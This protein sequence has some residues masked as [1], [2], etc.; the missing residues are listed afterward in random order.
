MS[1]ERR[2]DPRV[3]FIALSRDIQQI[4]KSARGDP[5]DRKFPRALTASGH[6][7]P[8]HSARSDG[9]FA[10]QFPES[11]RGR[12]RPG[13]EG[14]SIHCSRDRLT[15]LQGQTPSAIRGRVV[16]VVGVNN[17]PRALTHLRAKD[18]GE[19]ASER[20]NKHG[21]RGNAEPSETAFIRTYPGGRR[22]TTVTTT[23]AVEGSFS[24]AGFGEGPDV[25]SQR[26]SRRRLSPPLLPRD[27][28]PRQAGEERRWEESETA[29]ERTQRS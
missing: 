15:N 10:A 23:R 28:C 25:I 2:I 19:R 20:K 18:T 14:A 8:I 13:R 1:G 12:R 9:F 26:D 22:W 7:R 6:S 4:T 3:N 29:I 27:T 5:N 16:T 17:S 21:G 24:S 11:A